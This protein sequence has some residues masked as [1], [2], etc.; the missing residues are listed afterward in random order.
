MNVAKTMEV[1]TPIN[2]FAIV[3]EK[4]FLYSS[5]FS[6][7]QNHITQ[8]LY[9]VCSLVVPRLEEAI[10]TSVLKKNFK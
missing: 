7:K 10:L 4:S 5:I 3:W 6:F 2:A 9:S 1:E 8:L